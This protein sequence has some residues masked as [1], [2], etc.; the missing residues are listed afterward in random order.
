MFT[1]KAGKQLSSNPC[2]PKGKIHIQEYDLL[3]KETLV[4][5]HS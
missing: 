3:C 2:F 5:M 4:G 1:C